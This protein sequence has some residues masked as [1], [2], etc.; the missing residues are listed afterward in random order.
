MRYQEERLL[1]DERDRYKIRCGAVGWILVE[2]LT[3]SESVSAAEDEL[4]AIRRR[5]CHP[6]S[7]CYAARAADVFDYHLLT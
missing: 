4:I 1:D 2:R 3:L 7:R 5:P 6:V